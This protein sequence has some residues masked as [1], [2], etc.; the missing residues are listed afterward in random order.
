M[1]I[2]ALGVSYRRA[3]VELLER[4]SF[5]PD[6][7]PKA[8]QRLRE[9][10]SLTEGVVLST[11]NRVEVYAN[12]TSYH[13][14]FQDVKRFLAESREVAPEEFAEPLYAH[15]ETDA[16]EHLFDVA[17][18]IDSVVVG[19]PQILTQVRGAYRIAQEEGS[20]GPVLSA[21]FRGAIRTGRRARTETGIG[22]S[23]AAYV[24]AGLAAGEA[25]LGPLADRRAVVVGAGAM[26][27]LA[28][29]GLRAAGVRGDP[30][31]E[32]HHRPGPAPGGARRG[33]G[34]SFDRLAGALSQTD[35]IVSSTA[36]PGVVI[37][38]PEVGGAGADRRDRPLFVLDLAVPRD[39]DPLVRSVPG[40]GVAD[41]DDLK[42][43]LTPASEAAAVE[44]AR[45]RAIVATEVERFESWRRAARLAPLIQELRA[46]GQRIQAAELARAAPRLAGLTDGELATVE[47]LVRSVV[48]KL[49]HEPIVRLKDRS[50]P[51]APDEQARVLAELFGLSFVPSR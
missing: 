6:E 20:V 5:G 14:G 26:A 12:V 9:G 49:L 33:G 32:P 24:E 50:G 11:C 38:L 2:L 44:M 3:T 22:A 1:P 34:V 41:L 40:I 42:G 28:V 48:A 18:G 17:A 16:A 29:A 27:T 15:Y 36:A 21:L 8:Y 39:V 43:M 23:A 31:R 19:E 30:D 10:G 46:M 25:F 4:L 13:A 37:G 45:V 47:G 51:R 35:L 7:W